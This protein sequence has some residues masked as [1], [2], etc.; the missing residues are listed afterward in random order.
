MICVFCK[1]DAP[2]ASL[3][4]NY[5]SSRA[6][7]FKHHVVI[8]IIKITEPYANNEVI[9]TPLLTLFFFSPSLISGNRCKTL[10]N[11]IYWTMYVC[12]V[13]NRH[14]PPHY[15]RQK[16]C[17]RMKRGNCE[18]FDKYFFQ[19]DETIDFVKWIENC[20]NTSRCV[21][22]II[23]PFFFFFSFWLTV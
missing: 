14:T 21:L 1:G 22:I 19:L 15:K 4:F 17:A 3:L 13:D 9:V 10:L 11:S 7:S 12:P 8:H 16:P 6:A 23:A 2:Y 20:L 5:V 18:D